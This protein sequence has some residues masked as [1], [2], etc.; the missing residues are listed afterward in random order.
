MAAADAT[1]PKRRSR[2]LRPVLGWTALGL[3]LLALV[4]HYLTPWP[5]VLVIRAIFNRGAA[6]ASAKL[7]KHLPKD[8]TAQ[9]A[10]R[11]DPSDP[12]ALLDIYRPANLDPKAPTIVWIH[13]GGFVSGRRGDITNYLKILAGRGYAVV[14][15]DYTIAPGAT[16][17]TPIRQVGQALAFLDREGARLKINR[18]AL[19]IAGDSAG[20]QIAAQ[21][22]NIVTAPD[23]AKSVDIAPPVRPDQLR[24]ALLYCGVYDVD[25]L[26]SGWFIR[27][28]TWAYSGQR[29][30]RSV[31]GFERF[32]VAHY[33]TKAF[34]PAFISAGNAD[35]LGPQSHIMDEALRK[36]DVPVTSLFYPANHAAKLAHEYQFDL[37]TPDGQRALDASSTW[38]AS[39]PREERSAENTAADEKLAR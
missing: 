26:G 37:N 28:V 31:P 8:V 15:I 33:V 20:A 38:L 25:Q 14:N 22:A 19:V 3:G 6:D 32:S 1:A 27:T 35:P 16:Y 2:W 12:E 39:L 30:W 9:S 4:A 5:S 21:M 36:A 17:P 13:G 24:G 23:Y 11:Y 34:P 7:E 10:I 18:N 29:D